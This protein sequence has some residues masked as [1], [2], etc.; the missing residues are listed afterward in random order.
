MS[1]FFSMMIR[2]RK[3][4]EKLRE[5]YPGVSFSDLGLTVSEKEQLLQLPYDKLNDK[6]QEALKRIELNYNLV[7]TIG[8]KL[9]RF[10]SID[11]ASF[12]LKNKE[13]FK[14]FYI[15]LC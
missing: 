7:Q 10:Y 4:K 15:R 5:K 2:D 3:A 14:S 9:D 13:I 1:M 6:Q 11:D 12:Y 8:R